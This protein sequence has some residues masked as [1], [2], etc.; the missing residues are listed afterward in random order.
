[1]GTD[2]LGALVVVALVGLTI[3]ITLLLVAAAADV[4]VLLWVLTQRARGHA[5]R[6]ARS[7]QALPLHIPRHRPVH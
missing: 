3:P 5:L 1:M 7:V 2:N 4:A 6:I